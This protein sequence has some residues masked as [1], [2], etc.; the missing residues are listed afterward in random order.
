MEWDAYVNSTTDDPGACNYHDCP[1]YL[2]AKRESPRLSDWGTFKEFLRYGGYKRDAYSLWKGVPYHSYCISARGDTDDDV[3]I[4]NSH[5][6]LN[7]KVCKASEALTAMR[8]SAVNAPSF[9]EK[10]QN[11]PLNW[12][13]PP[14]NRLPHVGMPEIWDFDW[15]ETENDGWDYCGSFDADTCKV[16]N[17]C[18]WCTEAKKCLA[19][20]TNGPFFGQSCRSG[21]KTLGKKTNLGL[22]VGLS[23]GGGVVVLVVLIVLFVFVRQKLPRC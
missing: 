6:G 15:I 8:I 11:W 1:R 18:G 13:S 23:A 4:R 21:W 17:F 9:Q 3:T 10:D 14:L 22:I 12:S 19:G 20:D 16:T 7:T 5:G 2:I